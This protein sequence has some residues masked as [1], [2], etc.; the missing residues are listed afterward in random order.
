M[1][2]APL[3]RCC[4][5]GL[6]LEAVDGDATVFRELAQLLIRETF[7][8]FN[9]I[10]RF[11]AAGSLPE[12]GQEA[13]SLKGT[14]ATVGADALVQLLQQIEQAG[15]ERLSGCSAQQLAG[16]RGLLQGVREDMQCFLATL[17]GG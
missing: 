8:R 4:R 6:L 2:P 17:P 11:S 1:N 7:D 9:D 14:A 15:L 3:Y 13:H 10:A 16:L 5:P 12:M